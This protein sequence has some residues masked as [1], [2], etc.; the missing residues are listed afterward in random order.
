MYFAYIRPICEYASVVWD[1]APRL[2]YYFAT[3]EKLQISAARIVTELTHMHRKSYCTTIQGGN[4]C[5]LAG[6]TNVYA[7]FLNL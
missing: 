2:D 3:I 6:R 7:Y 5:L 1:S 4:A